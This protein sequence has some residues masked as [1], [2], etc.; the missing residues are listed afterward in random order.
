MSYS[1]P[2]VSL[3]TA[4]KTQDSVIAACVGLGGE[5]QVG[6]CGGRPT[7]NNYTVPLTL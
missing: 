1:V 2:P 3:R 5:L 4:P 7:R 6:V